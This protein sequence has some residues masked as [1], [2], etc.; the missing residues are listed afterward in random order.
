MTLAT[1]PGNAPSSSGWEACIAKN[2]LAGRPAAPASLQSVMVRRLGSRQR[3]GVIRRSAG[4]TFI[5]S[6]AHV[7]GTRY[8]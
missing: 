5:M 6:S 7:P 2:W 3:R 8:A 1:V 4:R